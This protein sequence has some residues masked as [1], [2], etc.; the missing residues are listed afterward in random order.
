MGGEGIEG[1]IG[2]INGK[3]T[4]NVETHQGEKQ[5]NSSANLG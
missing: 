3:L 4:T 1:A 2:Q 5:Q